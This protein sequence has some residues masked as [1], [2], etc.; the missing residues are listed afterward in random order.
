MQPQGDESYIRV[1]RDQLREWNGRYGDAFGDARKYRSLQANGFDDQSM[2]H[3]KRYRRIVQTTGMDD[4]TLLRYWQE[5]APEGQEPPPESAGVPPG[6]AADDR[7]LTREQL[8]QVLDERDT[9]RQ[10]SEEKRRQDDQAKQQY[11]EAR[12]IEQQS[13]VD[14]LKAVGME[15]DANGKHSEMFLTHWGIYARAL[16]EAKQQMLPPGLAADIRQRLLD[17]SPPAHVLARAKELYGA[18]ASDLRA[19]H[20]AAFAKGQGKLP[21]ATLAAGAAGTEPPKNWEDMNRTERE[22]AVL[23]DWYRKKYGE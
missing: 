10:K 23:G 12:T 16:A 8:V 3:A 6:E 7:Y 14:C 1:P 4:D 18:K 19:Q 13:A 2:D 9:A 21:G 15:P 20:I 11:D 17:A 22:E 5:P